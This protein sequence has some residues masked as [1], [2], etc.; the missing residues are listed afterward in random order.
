MTPTQ[1]SARTLALDLLTALRERRG[2]LTDLIDDVLPRVILSGADRRL[3]TAL[4]FGVVRRAA[5]LDALIRPHVTRPWDKVEPVWRDVLRLGA[6]QLVML[7]Q[8]PQHAAVHETV[9]LAEHVGRPEAKG[10]LNGILRRIAET[11][12]DEFF[13]EPDVDTVP[14]DDGRYRKL[15]EEVMPDP[16]EAPAD[17]LALGFGLPAWFADRL[18]ARHED[19]EAF[20]LA[21]H[22]N[23]VPSIWLR[24]NT[25]Q[26]TREAFQQVLELGGIRSEPGDAPQALLL[27]DG[28][29]IRD[30]PGYHA[31]EFCVQDH[32][33][34]LVAAALQVEPGMTVLDLCAAPG[35]KTTHLAELMKNRGRI[36]ACDI[37]ADRLATVTALADRMKITIIETHLLSE[38]NPAPLGPFD[39]VLVDAP[40]SNTGVLGRRPE[41]RHRFHPREFEHLM[42]LQTELLETAVSRVKP[43]GAIVY[44]TCSIDEGENV[45]VV[46]DVLNQ[47]PRLRLEAEAEAV[48]GRP[49]DGGYWARLR[50]G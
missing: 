5:T 46:N 38:A 45:G 42:R 21:F 24:A 8:V 39:A 9:E 30:I 50:L 13:D 28:V 11:T 7:N 25:L 26:L 2:F 22:F 20:R 15:T 34:Q 19:T 14:T 27:L 40:C 3:M 43:G 12:T 23:A 49:S 17:Y 1:P 47:R 10:F 32:A 29:P 6:Y 41:V 37:D 44:S 4:V 18:L 48:P 33:S 35:G 31:G 36:I 16:V